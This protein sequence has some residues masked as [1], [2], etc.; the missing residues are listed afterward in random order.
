MATVS[1]ARENIV[2]IFQLC[3]I[4]SSISAI[5]YLREILL[6]PNR[7]LCTCTCTLHELWQIF[8]VRIFRIFS[9]FYFCC[10]R[11]VIKSSCFR[12]RPFNLEMN[13]SMPY[14]RAGVDNL[15]SCENQMKWM[16]TD[17]NH[18]RAEIHI[19]INYYF[20]F[21]LIKCHTVCDRHIVPALP[22]TSRQMRRYNA[23]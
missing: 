9:I 15:Y 4:E 11:D 18:W 20:H 12:P 22:V 21:E 2:N 5:S 16:T 19:P 1:V 8:H 10:A 23:E 14:E 17:P 6:F 13:S 3:S 7:G